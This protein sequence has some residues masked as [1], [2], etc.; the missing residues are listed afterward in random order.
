MG[1]KLSRRSFLKRGGGCLLALAAPTVLHGSLGGS[2]V[3]S[4]LFTLGVASGDPTDHSVVLW[5]CLA[6]DPLNGGG[7]PRDPVPVSYE[8]ATDSGMSDIVLFGQVIALAENGHTVH[9]DVV[10]LPPNTWFYYRFQAL[11]KFSRVGRTRTFPSP[12]QRTEHLRFALVS[13]QNYKDG[14]FTAYRDMLGLGVDFVVHVGDY[15]YENGRRESDVAPGRN[16]EDFEAF[17]V[18]DYR[19]RYAQYRLDPDLQNIHANV[20][21]LVI[22]DDHEVD[23]NYAGLAAEELSPTQG[24][25][26]YVRRLN[27]YKVYSEQMPLGADSREIRQG[28]LRLFRRFSFGDLANFNMLDTRQYRSDQP[29]KDGYGSTDPDAVVLEQVVR[30]S[31]FDDFGLMDPSCTMLGAA[32]EHLLQQSLATSGA[33]WN[34]LA[35][36]VMVGPF[37]LRRSIETMFLYNEDTSDVVKQAIQ[38]AIS[39]VDGISNMDFWDG[40]PAGRER[41]LEDLD[42]L[43]PSNPIILSGDFHS[44]WASHVFGGGEDPDGALLAVEFLCTSISSAFGGLDPRPADFVYRQC[45]P[46]NPHVAYFNGLYRGYSLC[47]VTRERWQTH[48]RIVYG[49][50]WSAD[51]NALVPMPDSPV[52]TDA[53]Y[54]I[55]SGFNAIGSAER[56][57]KIL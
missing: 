7:M 50:R 4:D 33:H 8:V 42:V 47:D 13:C 37:D 49:N 20:P 18:E 26:F 45:L 40:C 38:T 55:A 21:F 56:L 34:V 14:Y 52:T 43:R 44:A 28:G 5:T 48:H 25:D 53:V 22:P 32:Q 19:R 23:N 39:R 31:V 6:P 35:Q 29:A 30:E 17:S 10:G 2:E 51:P 3:Q 41:L 24:I 11:G 9:A 54:E 57:R 12:L 16:H 1:S 36:Q 15:I 46:D 27:A